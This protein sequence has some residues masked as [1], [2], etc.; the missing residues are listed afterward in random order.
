LFTPE[1]VENQLVG[2]ETRSVVNGKSQQQRVIGTSADEYDE[3]WATLDNLTTLFLVEARDPLKRM[4]E[5]SPD[6]RTTSVELKETHWMKTLQMNW[7]ARAIH[8]DT[9]IDNRTC[10]ALL[11]IS[12]NLYLPSF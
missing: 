5:P 6:L 4:M 10:L 1:G 9:S 8:E 12:T 11:I 3:L 2:R 7:F